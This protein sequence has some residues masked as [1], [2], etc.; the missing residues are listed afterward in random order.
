LYGGGAGG[1]CGPTARG[2]GGGGLRYSTN[3][4]PVTPGTGYTVVV[5]AGHPADPGYF[6][7]GG[8]G[9]VRI[10][11]GSGRTYPNTNTANV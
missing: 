11:W 4:I 9:A 1:A 5:G 2:G 7:A 3:S 10:I 6:Q 8:G